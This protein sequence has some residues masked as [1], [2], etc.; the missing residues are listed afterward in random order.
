M[1]CYVKPPTTQMEFNKLLVPISY[2]R[3]LFQPAVSI[4]FYICHIVSIENSFHL[5]QKFSLKKSEKG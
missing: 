4:F 1:L 2:Q 3:S 5:S